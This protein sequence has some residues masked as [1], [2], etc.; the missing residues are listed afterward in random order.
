[1]N[2][3]PP[4]TVVASLVAR[5]SLVLALSLGTHAQEYQ[6]RV[7]TNAAGQTLPY[8]L[9]TPAAAEPGR[10][11]PQVLFFHGAGERGD[12]NAA[13]LT[14]G[15]RLFLQPT[16]RI[17]HP[18]FVIAPQCPA[19]QRWVEMQWDGDTGTRPAQP[20]LPLRLAL[21]IVES[22]ALE[23]PMADTNRLYVT[24]LSMGGYATWDCITRWP[25]R[26]AAAVPICGGGDERTVTDHVA[27][28]PVWAF[29]SE[30]DGVVKV[31]RTR[32]MVQAMIR[33]GGR[34]HYFEYFGRGH[35][36]WD[37]AYAEPEL[38]PWMFAQRRGQPD[39]FDLKT[40]QPTLPAVARFPEDAAFPGRGPIR[41]PEWFR[42]LWSERRLNWWNRRDQDRGA[43]VFLGDSITQGWE[44]LARDFPGLK[45]ANRGISGDVTR[46]VLYRL[47]E[48]VLDLDPRA[49]V[50]LIGTNDLEENGRPEDVAANVGDILEACRT[51]NPRMPVVVC[52][53]MP[54]HPSKQRPAD[55]IRRINEL[56]DGRVAASPSFVRCDTYSGFAD[57]EGN[58]RPDEFPD[59]LHP[60][61]AGYARWRAA[62]EPVFTRLKLQE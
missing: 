15:T 55:A 24:G 28:V 46:G 43:V 45:V 30:D 38:L 13:Q 31:Q 47:K 39:A 53:V 52:K 58:A 23:F 4:R 3:R 37:A 12:D 36:S 10:Q 1:M 33:A 54:S 16:A 5:L 14:H 60:N 18:C 17:Q 35:N 56:V 22:I 44:S 27:R 2:N 51:H 40:P 20:S 26:F 11:Y 9:L 41:K 6:P 59:L 34:P 57:A 42:K 50:L 7:H 29:H 49:V 32:N 48:D 8:R 21:E 19:G 62:L 61:A 25:A